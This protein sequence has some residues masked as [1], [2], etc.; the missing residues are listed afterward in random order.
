MPEF[1]QEQIDQ[2]IA[3]AKTGLF[4]KEDLEKEVTRETD[5]RV[6]SGIQRGLETQKEKWARELEEKAK[7]S[8]E[9]LARKEVEEKTKTL[10][11]KEVE[12]KKK[13]N[14][15][16]A[17]EML[18]DADIPKDKYEKV[19]GM[20]VSDDEEATKANVQAFID[21]FVSTKNEVETKVKSEFTKLPPPKTGGADVPTK[22]D[23]IKMSYSEKLELKKNKPELYKEFI[24]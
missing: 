5:R 4:T 18:A 9:E 6:E 20:L 3:E 14:K 21:V 15:L 19:L 11:S 23:F 13:E 1:T 22:A 16:S 10:T 12:L 8:A 2:M 17:K 24:N 7:M